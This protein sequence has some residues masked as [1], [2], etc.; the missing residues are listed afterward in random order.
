M[1]QLPPTYREGNLKHSLR[2]ES[3]NVLG[4]WNLILVKQFY[5]DEGIV[6]EDVPKF[7]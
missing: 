7:V 3:L 4:I 2:Q 1:N 5:V 6:N